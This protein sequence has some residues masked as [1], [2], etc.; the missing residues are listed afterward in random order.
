M[1][2]LWNYF[3]SSN[4]Y[5][6]INFCLFSFNIYFCARVY[7]LD[8]S[9]NSCFN[10]NILRSNSK[11]LSFV[12]NFAFSSITFYLLI[13][14]IAAIISSFFFTSYSLAIISFLV[15]NIIYSFSVLKCS[16]YWDK[17]EIAEVSRFERVNYFL[18]SCSEVK[19]FSEIPYI[20]QASRS[21]GESCN[22]SKFILIIIIYMFAA[23]KGWDIDES[24][25]LDN[26][27]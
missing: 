26:L 19:S 1:Y 23:E 14:W 5:C 4:Y 3:Y 15:S 18:N 6:L 25:Y 2:S 8:F 9:S 20:E 27:L 16:C 10:W 21:L 17:N 7:L 11:T 13:F 22:S 24:H 12:S